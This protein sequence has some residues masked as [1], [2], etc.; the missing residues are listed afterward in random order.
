MT[1]AQLKK[2]LDSRLSRLERRHEKRFSAIDLRFS[3]VDERFASL[4]AKFDGKFAAMEARIDGK[5]AAGNARFESV[6]EKLDAILG[7]VKHTH[8]HTTRILDE[9]ERR[10][11]ALNRR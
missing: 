10:L 7:F 1:V 11:Q 4:E 3:G 8:E 6:S 9:H 2:H 5:V